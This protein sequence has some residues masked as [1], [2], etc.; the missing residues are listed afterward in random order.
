MTYHAA[1][2]DDQGIAL[3]RV[4]HPKGAWGGSGG[5][6]VFAL[7]GGREGRVEG[8]DAIRL[9]AR[10]R[11][12]TAPDARLIF[13]GFLPSP[14]PPPGR[15]SRFTDY[16][17]VDGRVLAPLVARRRRIRPVLGMTFIP[18]SFTSSRPKSTM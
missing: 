7:P 17:C 3:C 10:V 8:G 6:S 5:E 11:V 9:H 12:R 13:H 18:F 2:A 4:Q 1:V 16:G 15:G 14:Q